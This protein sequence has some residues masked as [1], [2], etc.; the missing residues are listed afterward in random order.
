[1]SLAGRGWVVLLCDMS[2]PAVAVKRTEHPSSRGAAATGVEELAAAEGTCPEHASACKEHFQTFHAPVPPTPSTNHLH[3]TLAIT[4]S[5]MH[6]SPG[7]PCDSRVPYLLSLACMPACLAW[8]P[9]KHRNRA[10]PI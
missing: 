1:M 10:T 3:D 9:S 6:I 4:C 5:A 2:V 8:V 7:V